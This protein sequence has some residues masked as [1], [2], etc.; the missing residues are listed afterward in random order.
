MSPH[1]AQRVGALLRAASLAASQAAAAAGAPPDPLPQVT[2]CSYLQPLY[3][4]GAGTVT[5][6]LNPLAG[7]ST[8][9][10][11]G[12]LQRLRGKTSSF[13]CMR[14]HGGIVHGDGI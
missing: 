12:P 7:T 3:C 14:R 8:P 6:L 11:F 9:S 1:P 13:I 4:A 10:P 2:R 5:F